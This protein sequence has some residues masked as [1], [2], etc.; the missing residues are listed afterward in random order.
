MK[1][2]IFFLINSIDVN[3]GG[4]TRA[5]LKQASF[6]AEMGYN[7]YMLTFNFN[8]NYPEIRKKLYEM[9]KVH[10]NVIIPNMYEELEG[11]K[12]PLIAKHPP[13]TA[14]LEKL[15]EGFTLEKRSDRNAYRVHKNGLYY[16]YISLNK[17]NSLNFIDYYDD[18]RYRIK[19]ETFDPWG[20]VKKVTY[21]DLVSNKTRQIVYYD[22]NGRAYL[23]QWNNPKKNT[24]QRI[25][26]FDKNSS[27]TASYVNDDV[28]HKIDWLHNTIDRLGG[29]KSVVVSDTRS[30]DEVL[31]HLN[32]PK[33]AKIWRMHS[34]HLDAPFTVDAPITEKVEPGLNSID[35]FD[36]SVFLT[37]EQKQ[38]VIRRIGDKGNIKVIPHYHAEPDKKTK[39]LKSLFSRNE[40]DRYEEKDRNLAVIIS[41]LSSLKRIEH[42]IKAFKLVVDKVPNAKLEIWG[43]GEEEAKLQRLIT[44]SGLNDHIFLKG[45]THYPDKIYQRGLFS[46]MTSKK[47]G[48]ALS[49]LESMYN[50]TPV[51]SYKIKY[52]PSDMIVNNDNGFIIEQPEIEELANR[53]IH[54]FEN[55]DKAIEMGSKARKYIDKNFNKNVYKE[56]WMETVNSALDRKFGK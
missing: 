56:K 47:E 34:S 43:T 44:K 21:M 24:V 8:L 31:I 46:L 20:N 48:F 5:S 10:K 51:I 39:K 53:M 3:R 54:M 33:A 13:K 25:F 14:S 41:R 49:V 16:K 12:K 9:N 1:P 7:T 6:F 35:E 2:T 19:R 50:K 38:D 4:L 37:E 22:N 11:H 29:D 52:G 23:S 55:P 26:L 15:S 36:V 18:N 17:N 27:V 40:K 32:H 45:Y 28:S 30:T 42:S